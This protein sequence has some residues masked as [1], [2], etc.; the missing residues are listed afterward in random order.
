MKAVKFGAE[1]WL[2]KMFLTLDY[3]D[4]TLVYGD[5]NESYQ[6]LLSRSTV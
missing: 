5:S 4:E 2:Y 3:V 1:D 6:A